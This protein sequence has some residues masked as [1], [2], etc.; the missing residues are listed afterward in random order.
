MCD[1]KTLSPPL[2]KIL[3]FKPILMGGKVKDSTNYICIMY[4]TNHYIYFT[5]L[6]LP[7]LPSASVS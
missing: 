1:L 6:T 4:C 5:V 7:I 2:I 3:K